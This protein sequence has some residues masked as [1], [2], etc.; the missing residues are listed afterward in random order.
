MN[1]YLTNET[2]LEDIEYIQKCFDFLVEIESPKVMVYSIM[3]F[4]IP[5]YDLEAFY[6]VFPYLKTG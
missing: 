5:Q 1:H 4:I 3:D 6:L 2:S